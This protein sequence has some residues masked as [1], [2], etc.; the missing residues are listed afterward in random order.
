MT[1]TTKTTETRKPIVF[2]S[3]PFPDAGLSLLREVADMRVWQGTEAAPREALM[4]ALKEADAVFALPPTDRLD[5]A[6][7][8][9]APHL[10]VI[11][12]FGVGYDYV[13]VAE[14]TRRGIL[15]CN[16]PGTLTETT[17]DQT[18]ALLL[19]AARHVARADRYVRSGAWQGYDPM[20]L[21]GAD[22]HGATLG[23]VGLG[24]IGSAVA[25][26]ASGFGMRV[27]Y[28]GRTRRP[29]AEVALEAE[30]RSLDDLLRESDFVTINCALTPETRGL[31][32]AR[33]LALMKPTAILVNTARGAIVDQRAL[34]DA[35][36]NGRIAA[37]GV[38][39]FEQEPI[40]PDDPL[41]S[42]ETAVLAPHLGSATYATRARMARV[43]AENIVA[44]LQ[45]K[46]PKHL[47]NPQAW[48]GD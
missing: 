47:V 38:D 29:E 10:R 9:Q 32:G 4:E 40:S 24:T 7:M 19:A 14:A 18:W 34:A 1:E 25:R 39:V 27:R 44:A 22:V 33:E 28:T 6:A 11:S 35:L 17:A 36:Q 48:H 42:C 46:R 26:R 3:W 41:L 45:G 16:T 30:Y 43:A 31:I 37:A 5:S 15:V 23:I 20:L 13:D 8:A 2:C 21:L 12:G